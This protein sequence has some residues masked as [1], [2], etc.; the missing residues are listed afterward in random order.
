MHNHYFENFVFVPIAKSFS[1]HQVVVM[2][3]MK[4][5]KLQ[6]TFKVSASAEL[7]IKMENGAIT[8]CNRLIIVLHLNQI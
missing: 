2:Q 3:F 6:I 4:V 1:D 7:L 8:N 5:H